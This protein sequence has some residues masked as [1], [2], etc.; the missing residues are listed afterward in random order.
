MRG[1]AMGFV[2]GFDLTLVA[3]VLVQAIAAHLHS[4]CGIT[5]A[6]ELWGLA[7]SGCSDDIVRVGFPLVVVERGGFVGLEGFSQPALL[8]D[9]VVALIL[10]LGGGMLGARW[11]S[12][13]QRL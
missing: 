2:V 9:I 7:R 12:G 13:S 6:L 10:C 3:M 4:D 11:V 5:A 8:I 1:R